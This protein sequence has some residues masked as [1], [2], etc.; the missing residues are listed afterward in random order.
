[1][2]S[3]VRELDRKPARSELAVLVS[4]YGKVQERCSNV[5]AKQAALIDALQ[6]EQMR[7]RA[8][9]VIR[10][11]ALQ[12]ERE[13]RAR[14]EAL[15]PGL[16]RRALLARQIDHLKERI[17][18]L[19]RERTRWRWGSDSRH[20]VCMP[21]SPVAESPRGDCAHGIGEA[22]PRVLQ[23]VVTITPERPDASGMDTSLQETELVICRT[24]C[25]SQG[26]YWRV[27]DQCRRTGKPCILIDE[28]KAIHAMRQGD[29]IVVQAC[30][31]RS[32]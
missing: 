32:L 2:A 13:G 27:Q 31:V 6:A 23:D 3:L 8:E 17:E 19:L 5:I 16:P 15:V 7:L 25:I 4:Q 22:C 26:D 18:V 11:T 12:F 29:G 30:P 28:H 14:L 1:M 10:V 20:V 9:L 21:S 24:G